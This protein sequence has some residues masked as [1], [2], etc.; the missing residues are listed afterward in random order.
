MSPRLTTLAAACALCLTGCGY[1]ASSLITPDVTS[2]HVRMFD[3]RTFRHEI[4]VALTEAIKDEVARRTPLKIRGAATA[5]S[6]LSG[7]ITKVTSSVTSYDQKDRVFSQSLTVTVAFEWRRRGDGRVLA[8]AS[9]LST[10]ADVVALR[11]ETQGTATSEAFRDLA[12]LV[13]ERMQQDF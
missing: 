1:R 12:E 4:E 7:T 9:G 11:N 6:E 13:V 3:N 5:D 2:V 10:S 8:R